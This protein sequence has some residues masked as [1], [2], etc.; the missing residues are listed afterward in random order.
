M[1]LNAARFPTRTDGE[2]NVLRL[3]EQDRTRWNQPMIARGM[4]HLAQSA[5]G[6]EM[7]EYHLEAGI[8]ACHCAARDYQ[9]TDW[10]QILSIYDR[11]AEMDASPV[12]ALNRAIAIANI[13]GARAGLDAIAG[14]R[15][16]GVLE[17]YYLLHAVRG[18]F[19]S[20]LDD[21]Q[22]AASHFRKSIDLAE[23]SSER[24][25]LTKRLRACEARMRNCAAG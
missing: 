25:F 4:F 7:T 11:L 8:A 1:L 5:A 15:N 6:N 16:L 17:N 19:E 23:I 24:L 2:G 14:I 9:S 13:H 3:E 20:R 22:A 21:S 10:R 18:E 12:I